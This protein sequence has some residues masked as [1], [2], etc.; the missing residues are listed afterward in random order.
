MDST[1]LI[2]TEAVSP[3]AP[4]G[5]LIETPFY[6]KTGKL[7]SGRI[8]GNSEEAGMQAAKAFESVL[9]GKLLDV[10]KDTIGEWGLEKDGV[11]KQ[12]QGMFSMYLSRHIADNGGFGLW[13][14]IYQYL[15]ESS[16][17]KTAETKCSGKDV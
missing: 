1:K 17:A 13:E 16:G 5:Q 4:L 10:M 11:S 3:P 8:E 7:E 2:L 12:I 15:T 9:I 6:E 14:D